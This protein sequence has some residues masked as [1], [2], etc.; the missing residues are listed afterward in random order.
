MGD[1][2]RPKRKV[3]VIR[4]HENRAFFH[5][6]TSDVGNMFRDAFRGR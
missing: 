5:E 6:R 4:S 3:R 2:V 1:G